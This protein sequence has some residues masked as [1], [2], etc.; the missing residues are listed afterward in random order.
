MLADL[1]GNPI[2]GLAKRINQS[3]KTIVDGL[4]TTDAPS[5]EVGKTLLKGMET[6][7]KESENELEMEVMK[8]SANK[9]S[10]T[11]TEDD[12]VAK[13]AGPHDPA[14]IAVS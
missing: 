1:T 11:S 10:L 5:T 12:I 14:I 9:R 8:L 3:P 4:G 6:L 7:L 13:E 2:N